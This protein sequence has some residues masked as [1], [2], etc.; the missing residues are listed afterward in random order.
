MD[1][2]IE[3]KVTSALKYCLSSLGI[4]C[5]THQWVTPCEERQCLG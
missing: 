2:S 3:V 4:K 1:T 5:C